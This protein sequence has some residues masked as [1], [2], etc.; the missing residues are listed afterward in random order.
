MD[1]R[2]RRLARN[3]PKLPSRSDLP[4]YRGNTV[5]LDG[6]ALCRCRHAFHRHGAI[7]SAC[8]VTGCRCDSFFSPKQI[9]PK[10]KAR[11]GLIGTPIPQ[12][13]TVEA[14]PLF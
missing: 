5:Y 7:A 8:S 13:S 9:I 6:S 11:K 12:D 10:R 14:P 2:R 1:P 4:L 3:E